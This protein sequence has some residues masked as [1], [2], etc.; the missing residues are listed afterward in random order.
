MF[1]WL[2]DLESFLYLAAQHTSKA[3]SSSEGDQGV[4][5]NFNISTR[6]S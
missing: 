3:T 2:G 4:L 5:T 1:Y 6:K